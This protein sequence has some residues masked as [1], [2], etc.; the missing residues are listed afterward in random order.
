MRSLLDAAQRQNAPLLFATVVGA[1][2]A[3]RRSE[4]W[5]GLLSLASSAHGRAHWDIPLHRHGYTQGHA[6]IAPPAEAA[7]MSSCP[8]AVF[9]FSTTAAHAAF[10]PTP[11]KEAA[12]RAGL[13]LTVP[14]NLH[15][16]SKA[17][18]RAHLQKKKSKAKPAA[19]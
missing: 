4:A 16:A 7:R 6:H 13:Q 8:S 12:M 15:K 2:A 1:S 11:E 19:T 18:K 14:R 17:N 9:I 10:P 3:M 5:Q